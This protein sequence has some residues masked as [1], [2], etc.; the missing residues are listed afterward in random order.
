MSLSYDANFDNPTLDISLPEA[1]TA[2]N[3]DAMTQPTAKVANT[4][5]FSWTDAVKNV[6][7]LLDQG[8]QTYAAVDAA[9]GGAEAQQRQEIKPAV[10]TVAPSN[11][12]FVFGLSTPQLLLIAGG[13]AA[14]LILPRLLRKA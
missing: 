8:A 7:S 1:L 13:L 6:L 9:I 4:G 10:V 3:V 14:V 11:P 2:Q 5:G 12:A